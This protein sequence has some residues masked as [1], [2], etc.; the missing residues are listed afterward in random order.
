MESKSATKTVLVTGAS[1][2]IGL[3]TARTLAAHGHRVYAGMR[4]LDARNANAARELAAWARDTG[5]ALQP[6]ELDV[7]LETS[8]SAAVERIERR[9]PVDVLV[10]NAGVM[11]T[12][13]TEAFT[14]EQVAAS[15]DV[16]VFGAIRATRAVLPRMRSRRSGLLVHLS[17][18]AGRL[19]I[20]FFGVYCASKWALEAYA[21]TLDIELEDFGIRSVIV[22]PSGHATDLVR[23]APSPDDEPR[24]LAYGNLSQGGERMLGMFEVL[25]AKQMPGNNAQNVADRIL[26]IAEKPGEF[27]LRSPVGD[28]MGVSAINAGTK[29]TQAALIETLKPTYQNVTRSALS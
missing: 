22:E 20:P 17:S 24:R 18:A 27:P 6:I 3:L 12:G 10:N 25:F 29:S 21:E 13:V 9:H 23:T 7:T 8:V 19:A 2:G 26:A 4:D 16:N 11:P 5:N 1:R 14:L 15:F 28:D